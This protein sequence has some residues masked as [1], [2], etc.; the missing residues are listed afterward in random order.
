MKGYIVIH[1]MEKG[2]SITEYSKE[3][4]EEEAAKGVDGYFGKNPKFIDKLKGTIYSGDDLRDGELIVI[5]G[6]I[7]APKPV[8]I[9][10]SYELDED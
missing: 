10:K 6:E 4:F 9:I 2:V 5:K 1:A 7:V 3:E 8:K